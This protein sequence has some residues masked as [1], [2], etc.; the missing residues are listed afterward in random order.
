MLPSPQV[1]DGDIHDLCLGAREGAYV[2][3][4][5]PALRGVF[6]KVLFLY[7]GRLKSL[8]ELLS[9]PHAP[10]NVAGSQLSDQEL[11]DLVE[12]LKTL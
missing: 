7:E 4:N 6:R 5:T 11:K 1:T 9:G 12:Y 2:G 8:A 10:E 3:F